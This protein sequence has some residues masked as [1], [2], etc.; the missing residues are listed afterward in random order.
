MATSIAKEKGISRPILPENCGLVSNKKG[1]RKKL[2]EKGYQPR[3]FSVH[4]GS[5][6][7]IYDENRELHTW[8]EEEKQQTCILKAEIEAHHGKHPIEHLKQNGLKRLGACAAVCKDL[9]INPE[10]C[11]RVYLLPH[12]SIKIYDCY[13]GEKSDRYDEGEVLFDICREKAY[14]KSNGRLTEI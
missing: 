11:D 6:Y 5:L 9:G 12:S 13:V 3:L 10:T 1:L 8:S 4:L 2:I 14:K 7:R